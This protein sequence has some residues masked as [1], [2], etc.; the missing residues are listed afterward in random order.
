MVLGGELIYGEPYW[1]TGSKKIMTK[2]DRGYDHTLDSAV[3]LSQMPTNDNLKARDNGDIDIAALDNIAAGIN[4]EINASADKGLKDNAESLKQNISKITSS[5]NSD[6]KKDVGNIDYEIYG[7]NGK[8]ENTNPITYELNKDKKEG[9]GESKQG[10]LDHTTTQFM[11]SLGTTF[12]NYGFTNQRAPEKNRVL[13]DQ[14]KRSEAIVNADKR[15]AESE[16]SARARTNKSSDA[17]SN[18]LTQQVVTQNS[19][20][21]I[22]SLMQQE[23]QDIAQQKQI[24]YKQRFMADEL[25]TKELNAA[26][27]TDNAEALSKDKAEDMLRSSVANNTMLYA[28]AKQKEKGDQ[29][30]LAENLFLQ[31]ENGKINTQISEIS[32]SKTALVN[33]EFNL[34][35]LISQVNAGTT[36]QEDAMAGFNQ[37]VEVYKQ[38]YPDETDVT[39]NNIRAKLRTKSIQADN[40]MALL[41]QQANDKAMNV[42]AEGAFRGY[43]YAPTLNQY[44]HLKSSDG[45]V[46]N[47]IAYK[48]GGKTPEDFQF[49]QYKADLKAQEAYN[50]ELKKYEMQEKLQQAKLQIQ[51]ATFNIKNVIK[52]YEQYNKEINQLFG[53]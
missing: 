27:D 13:I 36:N 14:P 15:R 1:D 29:R 4:T 40:Q 30:Q 10:I 6:P 22:N 34:D 23:G 2:N 24:N 52:K 32:N 12:A 43:G 7:K 51:I 16:A 18:A 42:R 5:F 25:R 35:T 8:M 39:V 17:T 38:Q 48:K 19:F 46:G 31:K 28:D 21:N 50:K 44:A 33:M 26:I 53:K 49:E 20:D 41:R 47:P 11:T 3:P 37:A 45:T 9:Q